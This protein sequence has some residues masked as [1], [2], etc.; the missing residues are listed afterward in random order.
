M[1][2]A[3]YT[4]PGTCFGKLDSYIKFS[5]TTSGPTLELLA[6]K[7]P[8]FGEQVEFEAQLQCKESLRSF[9]MIP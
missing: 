7:S 1:P 5:Y 4:K 2:R 3:W 8:T 9:F 6:T